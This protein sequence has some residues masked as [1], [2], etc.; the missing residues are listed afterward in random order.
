MNRKDFLKFSLKASVATA[1]L[2]TGGIVGGSAYSFFANAEYKKLFPHI[3]EN[4]VSL[5]PNG[6][7]VCILGGGL[8]GLQ[9]GCELADRG[10]KVIILEKTNTAGG[11]LKTWKDKHFA[12]KHFGEKGYSREHGLHAIWGFYKNLREFLGR[13][14]IEINQLGKEDSFYYFISK[15]GVQSKIQNTSWSVPFDRIEMYDNGVYIPSREDINVPASNLFETLKTSM[16]MWGFDFSNKEDRLYLDSITFYDWAVQNGVSVEYIRHFF[17]ALAEMGFFMT[18]KECSALAIVNFM[19]LGNLPNDSKVD[20]YKWP[21]DETFI[22]PMIT[23]IQSKGGEFYYN[24]EITSIT[25]ENGKIVSVGTNENFPKKGKRCRVCGNMMGEGEYE[26]CPF[27]GAHHSELEDIKE[28]KPSAFN[29]DYFISAM[30]IP[31]AKKFITGTGLDKDDEYFKRAS[32]LTNAHILCVNL[33]YENSDAWKKRFPEGKTSAM[34]FMPT[35]Y[36]YLGFTSNWSSKQ[37]PELAEK[38]ID[39]IEVQVCKWKELLKY[40]HKEIASIVHNELKLILPELKDYSEF[41]INHWDTY[42]G[43]RPG[44]E[45]NRPGIQSPI[46]NLL[47]IGDWVFIDQHSVFM[48]RTNVMSKMVTNLLLEKIGSKDGKITILKSGTPDWPTDILKYI[49]SIK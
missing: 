9:A 35:G 28:M 32:Q 30:D 2:A 14:K 19:R 46:E 37:I 29:A 44:D 16:K 48:E 39:L 1:S 43:F 13:H 6:K 45:A 4:H 27:C 41:Y 40:S 38:N 21:P 22:N 5:S 18:T 3:P 17:D 25:R 20:F 31:G 11:K 34:D 49:T 33:L 24:Q 47:F 42:T 12:K 8:A 23:H 10:F 15:R 26:H 36:E 7:T